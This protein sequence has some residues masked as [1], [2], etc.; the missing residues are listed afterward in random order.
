MQNLLEKIGGR[1]LLLS[2]LV[3]IG[4]TILLYFGKVDSEHFY[5]LIKVIVGSFVGSNVL[6]S[7]VVKKAVDRKVEMAQELLE[8]VT[9]GKALA[10]IGGRKFIFVIGV[11]LL[12]VILLLLKT[13]DM[14]AYVDISN[15]LLAVYC[16]ANVGQKAVEQGV[17]ISV[18]KT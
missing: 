7:G 1:K 12:A 14:S 18:N 5:S 3:L 2:L 10:D 13:V 9:Q 6:Q 15:Y 16:L 17:T 8:T 11:Y 4:S